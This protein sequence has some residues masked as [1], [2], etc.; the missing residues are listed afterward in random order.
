M[1]HQLWVSK[2]TYGG[3]YLAVP[4]RMAHFD[5][6]SPTSQRKYSKSHCGRRESPIWLFSP[7]YRP[8]SPP[9]WCL[10]LIPTSPVDSA[11]QHYG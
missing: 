5:A 10:T 3:R 8:R 11:Y 9:R 4:S 6:M 1:S 7:M 2:L